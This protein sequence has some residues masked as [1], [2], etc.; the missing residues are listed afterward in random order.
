MARFTPILGHLSGKLAGNVFANN[1]GGA[2]IRQYVKPVNAN[3]GA[4]QASRA[5][6]GSALTSWQSQ[7]GI[8][9]S[10]WGSYADTFFKPKIS[11]VGVTY[12]GFNAWT[13]LRN[14]ALNALRLKR[15]T[16]M[17]GGSTALTVLYTPFVAPTIAPVTLQSA[18]I[19]ASTN[20][21]LPIILTSASLTSAAALI[22]TFTIGSLELLAPK[23]LE[24]AGNIPCGVVFYGSN[25]RSNSQAFVTNPYYNILGSTG[26]VGA[27]TAWP[28]GGASTIE[29]TMNTADY[30]LTGRKHWYSVGDNIRL[31]AF[32]IS[33]N[34]ASISIGAV[35]TTIT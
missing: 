22:A 2:Y 35:S 12:S 9:K 7:T 13:S 33:L 34:G 25:A 28:V 8:V 17:K 14:S 5:N 3:T 1:A 29:I 11:K 30:P 20:A 26:I 16:T 27:I 10:Q 18:M 4:Q 15:T 19:E 31:E 6:F 21:P 24:S 23:F 32:L